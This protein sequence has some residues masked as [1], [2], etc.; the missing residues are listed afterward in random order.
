[1]V[2][3]GHGIRNDSVESRH[4]LARPDPL[5]RVARAILDDVAD[6][7]AEQHVLRVLRRPVDLGEEVPVE[8][9]ILAVEL[10]VGQHRECEG[11]KWIGHRERESE[12]HRARRAAAV[13]AERLQEELAARGQA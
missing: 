2:A 3:E 12:T 5:G 11:R 1:M 6:L 13:D 9:G 8:R 4:R 7:R 10:R